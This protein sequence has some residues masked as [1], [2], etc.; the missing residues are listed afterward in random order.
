M[1][2]SSIQAVILAG[3]LGTR[4]R[5]LTRTVPKPMVP[6]A[7]VPY[8]EYQL[9]LLAG[10]EIRD[11]VILAG[12]LGDQIQH[13]FGDGSRLGI[14]IKYSFEPELLGTGGALRKAEALLEDA[15]LVLFGDSY[16]QIDYKDVFKRLI[17]SGVLAVLVI[18]DNSIEDTH[19]PNNVSVDGACYITRYEKSSRDPELTRV[20]AGVLAMRRSVL[21]FCGCPGAFSLEKELYPKLIRMRQ[22][23]AYET[24]QRFYDIG[25]PAGLKLF[26][27]VIAK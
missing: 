15:F 12:Y 11:I 5:P 26:E 16:L 22:L 13:H 19:V 1:N 2:A 18:Y 4:L 23:L 9:R 20:D 25:T 10:Q 6:V 24:R 7:G 27:Q 8:L 17:E 21:K 14:R 3:G